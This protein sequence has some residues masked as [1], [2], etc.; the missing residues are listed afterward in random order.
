[1]LLLWMG[2][3]LG[4]PPNAGEPVAPVAPVAR[5]RLGAGDSLGERM[6]GRALHRRE[7]LD[8]IEGRVVPEQRAPAFDVHDWLRRHAPADSAAR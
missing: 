3:L 5:V 2:L 1:M 4:A 6:F 8:R 7:I